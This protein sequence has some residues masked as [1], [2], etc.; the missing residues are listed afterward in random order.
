MAR[1]KLL[2]RRNFIRQAA[3]TYAE[4]IAIDAMAERMMLTRS[5]FIRWAVLKQLPAVLEART[6]QRDRVQ[7]RFTQAVTRNVEA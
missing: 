2:H 3:F 6:A 4:D 5:S 1:D 7:E